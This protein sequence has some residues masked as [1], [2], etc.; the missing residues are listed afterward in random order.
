[1]SFSLSELSSFV[2]VDFE[3]FELL[4]CGPGRRVYRLSSIYGPLWAT[5][6]CRRKS[7]RRLSLECNLQSLCFSVGISPRVY[8]VNPEVRYF[9]GGSCS[10][11]LLEYYVSH[12][13]RVLRVRDTRRLL[14]ILRLL[15]VVRVCPDVGGQYF[16]I[17]KFQF[18]HGHLYLSNLFGSRRLKSYEIGYNLKF[19][20]R[21]LCDSLRHNN[22][23]CP[24]LSKS[25]I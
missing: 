17:S 5:L 10:Y 24:L 9:C 11:S 7:C 20:L 18:R 16:D 25:L 15:D 4:S 8:V 23:S 12:G 6:Y 22:L 1:M 3:N 14:R 13:L 21:R 19:T 2:R